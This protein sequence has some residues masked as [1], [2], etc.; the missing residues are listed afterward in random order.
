MWHAA[1]QESRGSADSDGT[2]ASV[3]ATTTISAAAPAA[4]GAA[5]AS[6]AERTAAGENMCT[7]LVE[8][9]Y[10]NYLCPY[11]REEAQPA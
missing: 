10:H 3:K 8:Q 2:S 7:T 11:V 6:T 5:T 4:L 9:G 1:G